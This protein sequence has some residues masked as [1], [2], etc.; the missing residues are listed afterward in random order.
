MLTII[1][2]QVIVPKCD[3][4]YSQSRLW[5][6]IYFWFYVHFNKITAI[7]MWR[8]V[9][10]ISEWRSAGF[11]LWYLVI[12]LLLE[13]CLFAIWVSFYHTTQLFFFVHKES[14][15]ELLAPLVKTCQKDYGKRLWFIWVNLTLKIQDKILLTEVKKK[16]SK[17]IF[18]NYVRIIG[19]PGS[20][21]YTL[22]FGNLTA[23]ILLL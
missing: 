14:A 12:L 13:K 2:L 22:L 21:F 15:P 19:T 23:L 11:S 7:L 16:V 5:D 4:R 6:V 17:N 20:V 8:N 1:E 10:N 18:H 9:Q 3:L